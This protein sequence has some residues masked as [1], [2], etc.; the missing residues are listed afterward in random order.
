MNSFKTFVFFIVIFIKGIFLS[1]SQPIYNSC[2]NA[3]EIC[4]NTSV[5]INNIGANKT[6]CPDCEDDFNF[7]FTANN[8][9]WLKFKTN[10]QGGD[11]QLNFSNLT[12]VVGNNQDNKLQATLINTATPCSANAYTQIGNCV[13]DATGNF[14]LNAISLA[15]NS[16][17][18]VVINGSMSGSGITKAAECT[19]D[20]GLTGTGVDR[21]IPSININ[22]NTYNSC[23]NEIVTL[24]ASMLHCSDSTSFNWSI[25]GVLAAVTKDSVFQTTELKTGDIVTVSN[26]CFLLCKTTISSSSFPFTVN[27]IS[28]KAGKDFNISAGESTQLNGVTSGTEFS[29]SPGFA[30]S[31]STVLNPIANP[32]ETTTYTLT[33][34]SLTSTGNTCTEFDDVTIF[35]KQ[36]LIIPTTFSPNNDQIND[37]FEIF[38]IEN[39]PNCTIEIFDRW[40]QEVFQKTGY[41]LSKAWKGDSNGR[42]L[43]SG[44]YFYSLELKDSEKQIKKGSVTLIR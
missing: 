11:V 17:F 7:C 20:I 34:T 37:V 23:K 40:G 9:I 28:V 33:A 22:S 19:F 6:F 24:Y 1:Y 26:T 13:S 43:S 14:S 29:W 25:N 21:I 39:Y 27:E 30:L 35:V 4:P 42:E 15:A 18:Y 31:S 38:G 8:T 3:L 2:S 44:V 16:T 5:S 10:M 12:F 41:S 36:D 32:T